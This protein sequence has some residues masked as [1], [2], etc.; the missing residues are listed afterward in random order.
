MIRYT[1]IFVLDIWNFNGGT[2]WN[3]ESTI[4]YKQAEEYIL[5]IFSEQCGGSEY[6]DQ[7]NIIIQIS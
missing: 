4:T 1:N 2:L 5:N 6:L 3:K 7:L